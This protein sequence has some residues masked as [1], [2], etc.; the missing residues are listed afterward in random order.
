MLVKLAGKGEL[1]PRHRTD[2]NELPGHP[3]APLR[4]TQARA[5][6]RRTRDALDAG[7]LRLLSGLGRLHRLVGA[8]LEPASEPFAITSGPGGLSA[9]RPESS[10]FAPSFLAQ[11]TNTQAGAFTPFELQIEHQTQT[12]PSRAL[13][14]PAAGVA[15][16]AGE[17]DCVPGTPGRRSN[18]R[19]GKKARSATPWPGP[20]SA[21]NRSCSP[22]TST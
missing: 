17:R 2:H 16:N 4:R 10:R 3:T 14:E 8:T 12:R 1:E 13:N 6:R 11:S 15:A 19:C 20:A 9:A 22:E 7:R 5:L 21:Q 18:G